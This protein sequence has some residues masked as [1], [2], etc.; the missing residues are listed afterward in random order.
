MSWLN[1][2]INWLLARYVCPYCGKRFRAQAALDA[3]IKVKHTRTP[4]EIDR[5]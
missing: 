3:H 5:G 4:V 2:L 1:S